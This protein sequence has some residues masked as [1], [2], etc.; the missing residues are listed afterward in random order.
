MNGTTYWVQCFGAG[1]DSADC[2]QPA[3][4]AVTAKVAVAAGEFNEAPTISGVIWG[5]PETY[6]LSLTVN[7]ESETLYPEETAALTAYLTGTRYVPFPLSGGSVMFRSSDPETVAIKEGKA[8]G[9]KPG[10]VTITAETKNGRFTDEVRLTVIKKPQPETETPVPEKD[11]EKNVKGGNKKKGC[12]G[13][14]PGSH[15]VFR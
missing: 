10:T 13:C 14:V 3:N 2:R 12:P 5:T 6:Q 8:V 11:T 7:A 4:Q 15:F 9:K 1:S